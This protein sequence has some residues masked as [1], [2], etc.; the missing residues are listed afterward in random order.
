MEIVGIIWGTREFWTANQLVNWVSLF[1]VQINLSRLKH[2]LICGWTLSFWSTISKFWKPYPAINWI[3][4]KMR[5][6]PIFKEAFHTKIFVAWYSLVSF[7]LPYLCFFY[8]ACWR[9]L[10]LMCTQ[11]SR[12]I[13]SRA[14]CKYWTEQSVSRFLPRLLLFAVDVRL[15]SASLPLRSFAVFAPLSGILNLYYTWICFWF[16]RDIILLISSF[17]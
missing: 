14:F 11:A 6:K 2:K 13:V 7:C 4:S 10:C 8:Q 1:L 3:H 12:D 17:N 9:V 16:P 15:W 5:M